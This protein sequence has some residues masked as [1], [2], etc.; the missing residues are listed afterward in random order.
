[1]LA[2]PYNGRHDQFK[3]LIHYFHIFLT[4]V[5]A[6]CWPV[7]QIVVAEF[8]KVTLVAVFTKLTFFTRV[9]AGCWPVVQTV[10]AEFANVALV[11]IFTVRNGHGNL[12]LYGKFTKNRL[13]SFVHNMGKKVP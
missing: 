9:L 1:M 11:A 8:T 13:C 3:Y 10:V 4:R 12:D 2:S 7:V 5:L 6:G